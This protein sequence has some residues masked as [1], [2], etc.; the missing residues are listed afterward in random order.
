M[1]EKPEVVTDTV[2]GEERHATCEMPHITNSSS[3]APLK[4][5][6]WLSRSN[7]ATMTQ[8]DVTPGSQPNSVSR[9]QRPH[10]P[11]DLQVEQFMVYS[12]GSGNGPLPQ[13]RRKTSDESTRSATMEH[14]DA[15][16]AMDHL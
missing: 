13:E 6:A 10:M 16:N 4:N 2:Q 12:E 7:S 11:H 8:S 3:A 9:V 15:L 14:Y 1:T 5:Q